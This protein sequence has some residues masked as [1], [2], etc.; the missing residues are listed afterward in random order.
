MLPAQKWLDTIWVNIRFCE[1]WLLY[2]GTTNVIFILI[3][4]IHSGQNG[5][6]SALHAHCKIE[7]SLVYNMRTIRAR[8]L[9]LI[10]SIR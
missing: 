2:I 5:K 4:Y 7:Y 1:Y 6:I 9:C 8:I 3:L 10:I